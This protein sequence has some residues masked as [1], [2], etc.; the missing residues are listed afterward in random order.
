MSKTTMLSS[1]HSKV[2]DENIQF[3][4]F[5]D[6]D[7]D[8][9]KTPWMEST[10]RVALPQAIHIWNE[11]LYYDDLIYN[12]W[13]VPLEI[14]KYMANSKGYSNAAEYAPVRQFAKESQPAFERLFRDPAPL[15]RRFSFRWLF[16]D[17]DEFMC[18][19]RDNRQRFVERKERLNFYANYV[20]TR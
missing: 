19:V 1:G 16:Y 5:T 7:P 15:Y 3:R 10:Y 6:P 14:L 4:Q 12:F 18:A 11:A 8:Q 17:C 20:L 13:N 9:L 2:I